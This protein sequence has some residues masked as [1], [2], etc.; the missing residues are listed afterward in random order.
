MTWA[1]ARSRLDAAFLDAWA[2][3]SAHEQETARDIM[4]WLR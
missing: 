3:K 1:A 4:R 2:T